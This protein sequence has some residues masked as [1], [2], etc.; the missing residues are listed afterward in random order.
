MQTPQVKPTIGR[1]VHFVVPNEHAI[2]ANNGAKEVPAMV[3]NVFGDGTLVNLKVFTDGVYDTWR[4]SVHYSEEKVPYS[5][6][7]PERE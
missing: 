7:W 6:H 5:W 1:I 4:T 3:T 2:E